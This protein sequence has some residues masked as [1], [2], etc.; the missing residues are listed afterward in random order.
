MKADKK[1][2]GNFFCK[3][4]PRK[5]KETWTMPSAVKGAASPWFKVRAQKPANGEKEAN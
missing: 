2:A 3:C 1:E 4:A 5:R